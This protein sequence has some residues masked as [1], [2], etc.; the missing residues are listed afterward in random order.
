[1]PHSIIEAFASGLPVVTTRAGGIPYIVEHER[2]G[3]L[4][5]TDDADALADAVLR[6]LDDDGL[7]ERL[8]AEGQRDCHELYSW[9][10]AHHRWSALYRQLSARGARSSAAYAEPGVPQ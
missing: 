1:M 9:Q 8:I 10:A 5:P 6:V 7:V 4:V 2:N 3:L